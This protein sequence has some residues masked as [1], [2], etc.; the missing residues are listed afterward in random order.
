ML[1]QPLARR[2]ARPLARRIVR[3]GDFLPETLAYVAASGATDL[4]PLDNLFRYV[5]GAGL[6]SNFRIYPQKSA[7]NSGSGSTV[8]GAGGLTSNNGTLIGSPTWGA[9]GI[10]YNGTN[11]CCRISDFLSAATLTVWSR[12][13]QGN[14]GLSEG[15]VY[16]SQFDTGGNQ[17]SINFQQRPTSQSTLL[18][19]QRG[20]TG[21]SSTAVFENYD[22]ASNVSSTAD[23]SYVV[24]WINGGG[25]GLWINNTAESISRTAGTDQTARL[26]TSVDVILAALL[27]SGSPALFLQA[28]YTAAA[29]LEGVTPTTTQRETITNLINAL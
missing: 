21:V 12:L 19:L 15:Q 11:Q 24:Q 14:T 2:L 25:R 27:T 7:Q 1:A 4:Q 28:T 18:L 17:R 9:D 23:R 8:Y 5:I 6:W 26:N 29:F 20:S 16:F 13:T 3:S 22:T 10:A